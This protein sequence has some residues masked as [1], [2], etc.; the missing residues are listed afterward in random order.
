LL[1]IFRLAKRPLF[2]DGAF[3]AEG[4]RF[5]SPKALPDRSLNAASSLAPLVAVGAALGDVV[6]GTAQFRATAK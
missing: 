2:G 5:L 3:Q 6:G 4:P 1:L